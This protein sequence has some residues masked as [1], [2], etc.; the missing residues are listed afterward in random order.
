MEAQNKCDFQI[1]LLM[2]SFGITTSLEDV[3][4]DQAEL[5]VG[6]VDSLVHF[7]S[8]LSNPYTQKKF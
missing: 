8:L 5:P 2:K 7:N 6:D 1:D 4:S 3:V